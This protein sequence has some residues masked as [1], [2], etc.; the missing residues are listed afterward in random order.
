MFPNY[1]SHL[2]HTDITRFAMGNFNVTGVLP[3]VVRATLDGPGAVNN[4]TSRPRIPGPG[5]PPIQHPMASVYIII[6]A[7]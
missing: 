2:Q 6:G 1:Y 4:S 3:A 5:D 7:V